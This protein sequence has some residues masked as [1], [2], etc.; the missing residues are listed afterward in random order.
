MVLTGAGRVFCAGADLTDILSNG[1]FRLRSFLERIRELTMRLERS[2]LVVVA[3]VNG[4]ARAGGLELALACDV[5]IAAQSASFG[6][7]HIAHDILPG[8]GSTVRLPRA[9]GWPRAKWL[10]LSGA[11][12]DAR[13]ACDWGLVFEVVEDGELAAAALR[14]AE[15]LVR[16]RPQTVGRAKKLLAMVGEQSLSASLEAEITMLEA[17]YHSDAFRS[18]VARFLQHNTRRAPTR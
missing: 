12:I 9:V 16:A 11:S 18:G 13:Q 2:P 4:A 10:I 1:P 3:A 5:M 7:A 14:T 15:L 6:D 8:G 17:H